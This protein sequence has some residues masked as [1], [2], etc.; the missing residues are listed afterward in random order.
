M[1]LPLVLLVSALL[2]G[3]CLGGPGSEPPTPTPSATPTPASP[4]PPTPTPTP[5]PASPTPASPTPASPTP[6]SPTPKAAPPPV[7]INIQ[8][9]VLGF[10]PAS[11]TVP[12]GTNVTWVNKDT[13]APHTATANDASFDSGNLASGASY[14]FVFTQAGSYPYKCTLHPTMTATLTVA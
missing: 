12:I 5:T 9:V 13:V 2:L 11:K 7:T 3:G 14:S 1:R 4:T 10:D 6:A 8:N